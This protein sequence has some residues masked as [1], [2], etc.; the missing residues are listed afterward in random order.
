MELLYLH[1]LKRLKDEDEAE[2][3]IHDLFS[4]MW[5]KGETLNFSST[6]SACL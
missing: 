1:A 2:D 4:T 3:P 5:E 6:L